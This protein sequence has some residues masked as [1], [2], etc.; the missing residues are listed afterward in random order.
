MQGFYFL[1]PSV[2]PWSV[3]CRFHQCMRPKTVFVDQKSLKLC[4][5]FHFKLAVVLRANGFFSCVLILDQLILHEPQRSP[6]TFNAR[7]SS[8]SLNRYVVPSANRIWATPIRLRVIGLMRKSN[9]PRMDSWG[10]SW[11]TSRRPDTNPFALIPWYNMIP[12]FWDNMTASPARWHLQEMDGAFWP[13]R[14]WCSGTRSKLKGTY[15]TNHRF[16]IWIRL[17]SSINNQE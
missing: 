13:N 7:K 5:G 15:F 1:S 6:L 16:S 11:H 8:W 9:S 14:H 4:G 12:F 10:S 2:W 17:G 3:W